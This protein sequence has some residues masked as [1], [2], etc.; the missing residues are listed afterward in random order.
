MPFS[1]S[2]KRQKESLKQSETG[3]HA[4]ERIIDKST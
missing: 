2:Q 1:L 4:N 3:S